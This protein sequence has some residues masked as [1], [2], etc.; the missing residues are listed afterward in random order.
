VTPPL[1]VALVGPFPPYRGGIAHYGTRLFRELEKRG[2]RPVA[3]NFSRLYP[4]TFFPGS[5]QYEPVP[6]PD[7]ARYSRRVLD[8]ID[9]ISW[10]RLATGIARRRPDRLVIQWWHPF[11]APLV[12]TLLL[13]ASAARVPSTLI[14]HNV[15]PHEEGPADRFI[16]RRIYRRA[17]HCIVQATS[18]AASLQ[19]LAPGTRATVVP[20]PI[21]DLFMDEE[22]R[23][24][25]RREAKAA[26]GWDPAHRLVLFFGLVRPYKGLDLLIEAFD[27]V[28]A[29]HP[30]ARLL[31][32][33]ECYGSDAVYR[34]AVARLSDP[35][36]VR[37]DLRYVSSEE[38]RRLF[39]AADVVVLPYRHATQS[40]VIQTAY[41]AGRA[42]I[43]T[44]VGGLPDV[45]E[46]GVSGRLVAPE[47]PAALADAI[48]SFFD[49]AATQARFEEGV[50]RVRGRYTWGAL[51]DAIEAA[52]SKPA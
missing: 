27:A 49:G 11:F 34:S 13:A 30:D 20:H 9:P 24:E 37:L 12:G 22:L 21:Q 16:A 29:R 26:L 4:D 6:S 40:G 51:V 39:V 46:D 44:R 17:D 41:A 48:V 3:W 38:A 50:R 18:E 25:A 19:A 43:S 47:D 42:V 5:T 52:E 33:G 32:V 10:A 7:A 45:V 8:S 36:R 35:D 15:L 23:P 1:D 14:V 28:I 2:H 31:A